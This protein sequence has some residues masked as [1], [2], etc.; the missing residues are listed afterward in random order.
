MVTTVSKKKKAV[1]TNEQCKM[2]K[3]NSEAMWDEIAA[4]RA[5]YLNTIK[6][7][8]EKYHTSLEWMSGQMYLG[9]KL[10]KKNCSRNGHDTV[11]WVTKEDIKDL[12]ATKKVTSKEA[13]IDIENTM[14]AIQ[15]KLLGLEKR[16]GCNIMW[17]LTRGKVRDVFLPCTYASEP[18]Q[19]TFLHLRKSMVESIDEILTKER[20]MSEDDMPA[21]A[22][23]AYEGFII[24]WGVELAGWTERQVTNPGNIM[25]SIALARLHAAQEPADEWQAKI[26][27]Y[28]QWISKGDI[29]QHATRLDNGTHKSCTRRTV[30]KAAI[31]SSTVVGDSDEEDEEDIEKQCHANEQ[32]NKGEA[33]DNSFNLFLPPFNM[34]VQDRDLYGLDS[35][36]DG[37]LDLFVID[38]Q[39]DALLMHLVDIIPADKILLYILL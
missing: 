5:V 4:E 33:P 6:H 21:M 35:T 23:A 31:K 7:L 9:G 20:G 12:K 27:A 39:T 32:G 34:E 38:A 18:L 15:S 25:S 29:K 24:K 14:S 8:T 22:Y 13:A 11:V 36:P 37:P 16:T 28:Q 2:S 19:T 1:R 17:I 3:A 10:Q 30:T 26:D